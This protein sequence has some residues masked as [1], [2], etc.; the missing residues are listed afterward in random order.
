M[1]MSFFSST[2]RTWL[3]RVLKKEKKSILPVCVC[4]RETEVGWW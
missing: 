4:V 3:V 2:V 1:E